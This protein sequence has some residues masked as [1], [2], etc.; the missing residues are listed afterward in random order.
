MWP[1][2]FSNDSFLN[3]SSVTPSS[4]RWRSLV[5]DENPPFEK[6]IG[7]TIGCGSISAVHE[8]L[9]FWQI[10]RDLTNIPVVGGKVSDQAFRL[11]EVAWGLSNKTIRE[12][13]WYWLEATHD[14]HVREHAFSAEGSP[15]RWLTMLST[16]SGGISGHDI[17]ECYRRDQSISGNSI[18]R[19][20]T[21]GSTSQVRLGYLQDFSQ[22]AIKI[23]GITRK[24]QIFKNGYIQVLMLRYNEKSKD[25]SW[26]RNK[27]RNYLQH[28]GR[29]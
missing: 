13:R 15:C 5:K 27:S 18:C 19:V 16:T 22:R 2:C 20:E 1:K 6:P 3:G 26:V 4:S 7:D 23:F 9:G 10:F 11:C 28:T 17:S 8:M 14:L 12:N 25:S 29:R 24:F 21:K